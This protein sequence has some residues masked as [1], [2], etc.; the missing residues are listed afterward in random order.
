MTEMTDAQKSFLETLTQ[1]YVRYN[2]LVESLVDVVDRDHTSVYDVKRD[3]LTALSKS[4]H[5]K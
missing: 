1:A 3:I 4:L 5:E 2:K